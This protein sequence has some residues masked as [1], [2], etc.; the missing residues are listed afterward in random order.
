MSK[1]AIITLG[2]KQNK[3]ESDCM[4]RI[5][6]ENGYQ[7]VDQLD[8]ADIYII[9]TCAVTSEAEKKSRQHIIKCKKLNKDAKIIVCGCASQNSIE[10]FKSKDV[11]SVFGTEGKQNILDYINTSIFG[12]DELGKEYNS[13][14]LP[15]K[16][17]TRNVC[18]RLFPRSTVNDRG[19][20]M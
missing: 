19:I 2:C 14:V 20:D 15:D 8:V 1:V 16:F 5:L 4:A 12:R 17:T 3:Y 11:Y 7:V 6:R 13:P 18:A 9:N 10:Q